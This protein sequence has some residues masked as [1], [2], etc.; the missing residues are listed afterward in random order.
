MYARL[1]KKK[2]NYTQISTLIVKDC[3][4]LSYIIYVDDDF[5]VVK[6]M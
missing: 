5:M 6:W 3:F 4:L 2:E 1:V